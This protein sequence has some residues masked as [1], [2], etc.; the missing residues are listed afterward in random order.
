MIAAC[1]LRELT[2]V[3]RGGEHMLLCRFL[4]ALRVCSARSF[5]RLFVLSLAFSLIREGNTLVTPSDTQRLA[6]V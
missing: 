5:V 6:T 3:R 2:Y 4:S 1:E